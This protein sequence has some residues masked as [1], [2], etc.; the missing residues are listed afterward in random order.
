MKQMGLSGAQPLGEVKTKAPNSDYHK[1]EPPAAARQAQVSRDY[2][3]RAART[4]ELNGHPPGSDGQ[5]VT[6]LKRYN[7]G[8]QA[9]WMR[10]LYMPLVRLASTFFMYPNRPMRWLLPPINPNPRRL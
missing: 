5:M 9:F 10:F 2:S 1:L 7:G 8:P 4:D 6:A 3:K